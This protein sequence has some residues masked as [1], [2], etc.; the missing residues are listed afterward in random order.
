MI[1]PKAKIKSKLKRR[2]PKT[3]KEA[4]LETV[5]RNITEQKKLIR[6]SRNNI[7]FDAQAHVVLDILKT[8]KREFKKENDDY[9]NYTLIRDLKWVIEKL[10][11]DVHEYTEFD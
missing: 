6:D 10:K 2:N 5:D 3:F 9:S 7:E 11:E 4:I 8:L 1:K